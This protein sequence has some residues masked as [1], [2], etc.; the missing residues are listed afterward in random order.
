MHVDAARRVRERHDCQEG[1]GDARSAG[2]LPSRK[3]DRIV[4]NEKT[5]QGQDIFKCGNLFSVVLVTQRFVDFVSENRFTNFRFIHQSDYFG[6]LHVS[7][8]LIRG[9]NSWPACG[10][11]G[12]WS[13]AIIAQQ[14]TESWGRIPIVRAVSQP[15]QKS[16]RMIGNVMTSLR[17]G[18]RGQ[19]YALYFALFLRSCRASHSAKRKSDPDP[20][21]DPALANPPTDWAG[22]YRS[23]FGQLHPS[24]TERVEALAGVTAWI[25]EHE[26]EADWRPP[27]LLENLREFKELLLK[28]RKWPRNRSG[29]GTRWR[30]PEMTRAPDDFRSVVWYGTPY[31]FTKGQAACVKVLVDSMG[32]WYADNGRSN[33]SGQCSC[34]GY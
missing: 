16:P 28:A 15:S 20:A 13:A 18:D 7:K 11:N 9:C 26:D 29:S 10:L 5:W 30:R 33:G 17:R 1:S 21:C 3:I 8:E 25:Q 27:G 34:C 24:E 6:R 32:S 14:P 23:A 19:T 12:P 22:E 4:V 2:F 31:E